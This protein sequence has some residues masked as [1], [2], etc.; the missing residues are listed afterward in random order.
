MGFWEKASDSS[1]PP[2]VIA[3]F[4]DSHFGDVVR[5]KKMCMMAK[6]AGA[7]V[8][9]FQH[10][11]VEEEMLREIPMSKNMQEPL[12]DFLSKNALHI[13]QHVDIARFCKEIGIE[14]LCTPF[15]LAA[16]KELEEFISPEAYKIGSG[17]LLDHPTI[18]AISKF[19]KP[20]ILS[21]GMATVEEIDETYGF[22]SELGID[23]ALLSCTSGYPPE[24]TESN[25]G[26]QIKMKERY[27]KAIIGSSDH[28]PGLEVS[29]AS[30]ATG[31]RIIE[32]HI[33]D[34]PSEY[35][36]DTNSSITFE[37]LGDLV[38]ISKGIHQ[39]LISEKTIHPSEE[40][41]RSWAHRSLVY[42]GDLTKG[43]LITDEDIW[44]KRP[45]TGIPSRFRTE[46]IGKK[47]SID[48]GKNSLLQRS[49][50]E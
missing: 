33:T 31:A 5:A 47:L 16:A 35:G 30:V 44:G 32:K 42:L 37:E 27:P 18:E 40:V 41:V 8:A 21:T 2:V 36:P 34:D 25:L 43:H 4:G 48:V 13:R 15:S 1:L 19:G 38:Q 11:L 3:E 24:L 20:I 46:F 6:E 9:K 50:F 45:G 26:F 17:E 7:D 12:W 22:L 29:I 14:Y 28:F 10:H 23:F 39:S 49:D